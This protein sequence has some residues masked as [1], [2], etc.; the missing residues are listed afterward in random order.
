MENKF[1]FLFCSAGMSTSL[2][3]TKMR[4]QAN[5]YN[6]PVIIEAFP[7][8]LLAEKGEQADI[9][10]LGP[11]IAY[12]LPEFKTTFP[13]KPIEVIDSILYGKVDGL[14]VLKVAVGLIKKSLQQ[15]A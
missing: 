12:M 5:K 9:I 14:G 8:T 13:E 6:V 4:E 7:E 15:I 10:L 11:Q 1:I 3:V 2:L